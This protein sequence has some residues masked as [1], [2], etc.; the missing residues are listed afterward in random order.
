MFSA[1]NGFV[2]G[3]RTPLNSVVKI[4]DNSN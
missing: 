2:T 1:L 4:A 3:I